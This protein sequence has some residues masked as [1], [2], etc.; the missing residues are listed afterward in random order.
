MITWSGRRNECRPTGDL[1]DSDSGFC[2]MAILLQPFEYKPKT[3]ANENVVQLHL[4]DRM[5]RLFSGL[6]P[7]LCPWR[8]LFLAR[9]EEEPGS[10]I[11]TYSGLVSQTLR[12]TLRVSD[13]RNT[14]IHRSR[15]AT[16]SSYPE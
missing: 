12:V 5:E 9:R 15:G 14:L 6:E 1:V 11:A 4:R 13:R 10:V 2:S 7:L 16:L 3:C 8:R